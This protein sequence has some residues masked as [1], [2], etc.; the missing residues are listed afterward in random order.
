H[1]TGVQTCA[2][3]IY[4]RVRDRFIIP[5]EE[6]DAFEEVSRTFTDIFQPVHAKAGYP[7]DSLNLQQRSRKGYKAEYDFDFSLLHQGL[8]EQLVP[9]RVLTA[10]IKESICKLAFLYG[11]GPLEMQK[12]ILLAIDD[13]YR[14]TIEGIKK[15]ASEYYKMT[16]ATTA[17]KLEPVLAKATEPEVEPK[18]RQDEL[19]LYLESASPIDVL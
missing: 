4:R 16:V 6:M 10:P 2:L 3:P 14:L 18:T 1:V 19:I 17:P 12:V 11:W 5:A 8:S 13:D 15:S 9:K 7:H